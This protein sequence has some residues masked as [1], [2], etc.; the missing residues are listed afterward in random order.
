MLNFNRFIL[1]IYK[2][3]Y[4]VHQPN[5]INLDHAVLNTGN[6]KLTVITP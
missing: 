3:L 4:G 5:T 6:K 1:K 2:R